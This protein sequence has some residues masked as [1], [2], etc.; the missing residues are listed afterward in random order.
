MLWVAQH[1]QRCDQPIED[2]VPI[3]GREPIHNPDHVVNRFVDGTI[4][5]RIGRQVFI[6]IHRP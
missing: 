3:G 6:I 4:G 2:F 1:V 5:S